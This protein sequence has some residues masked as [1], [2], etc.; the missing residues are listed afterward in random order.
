MH[1]LDEFHENGYVHVRGALA[2]ELVEALLK[3]I[4]ALPE[5]RWKSV[6]AADEDIDQSNFRGRHSRIFNAVAAIP[7]L[8]EAID[9]PGVLPTLVDV[10][11]ENLQV[12]GSELFIRDSGETPLEPFHTDGGR[13]MR[14]VQLAPGSAELQVKI[15]F[16]LTDVDQPDSGNFLIIPGSHRRKPKGVGRYGVI[17][18]TKAALRTA[19]YPEGTQQ[20]LAKAGDAVIF[21]CGLWHAVAPNHSGRTRKSAIVRYGPLWSRPVDY[22]TQSPQVLGRMTERQRRLFGD[23]GENPSFWEYY[24]PT[25]QTEILGLHE[26]TEAR[27]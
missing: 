4:D 18:E 16:F 8:A 3:E 19:E 17:E 24:E 7:L 11:G 27:A 2:P 1:S 26:Q 22:V 21:S 13:F 5:E 25:G 12:L 20:V 15:Q 6:Y 14:A 23:L 9:H 10:V